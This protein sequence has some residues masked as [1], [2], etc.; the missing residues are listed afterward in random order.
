MDFFGKM[1]NLLLKL[2]DTTQLSPSQQRAVD[3]AL[4]VD[5]ASLET[6]QAIGRAAMAAH[7]PAGGAKYA[8]TIRLLVGQSKWPSPGLYTTANDC[9]TGERLIVSEASGIDVNEACAASASWPGRAGPTWL[10]DRYTMDGGVCQTSTH[11]DVIH[12]VKKAIVISLSDGGP[13]AA[14]QGLRLSSMPNTLPDEI[15]RLKAGGSDVKLIV[16]GL[17]PGWSH[18]ELLNPVSIKPALEY[19]YARGKAEAAEIKQF[20]A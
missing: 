19:G 20:W 15:A 6:V 4:S 9:Y 5:N 8:R 16:V 1:P 7:N 14:A 18:V 11:C 17:P 12:G 2:A 13:N 3:L 10:K